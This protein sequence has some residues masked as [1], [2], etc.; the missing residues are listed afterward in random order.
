MNS[1]EYYCSLDDVHHYLEKYG[2]AVVS[3]VVSKPECKKNANLAWKEF[4][5]LTSEMEN[6]IDKKNPATY[7]TIFE[8][9]PLHAMLLQHFGIGH[10]QFVWNIRQNINV[11]KVFAKLW[12]C[13]TKELLC[14][15]DGISF[16]MPP[17]ITKRGWYKNN[18]WLHTD[19]SSLKPDLETIQGFVSLYDINENDA[20][21]CIYEGSHKYHQD[22]FKTF[23]IESKKDWFKLQNEEQYKYF[24]DKQ[25]KQ[26]CI[27]CKRG[28]LVLWD[29]RL[30]HQG[31]EPR[32]ER[33][34]A[35]FRLIVYIC[36]TPRDRAKEKDLLKKQKA[37]NELR[38]TTH[39][40][41]KPILFGKNPRTY[42]NE[43]PSIVPI[44]KPKLSDL[45]E[46]LAGF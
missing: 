36:M 9:Y 33:T 38:M 1:K 7:K 22:F 39:N 20:S 2:V 29:S 4:N 31:I 28:S 23:D 35:N 44:D 14:S 3:D 21:L 43:L 32:K 34:E 40:P 18:N 30:F 41:H 17:E 15:F 6:P 8:F 25:C 13:S 16:H 11:A 12:G 26:V 10:M 24:V 42:G 37:F 46:T 19:Q 27:K 5:K 45:G